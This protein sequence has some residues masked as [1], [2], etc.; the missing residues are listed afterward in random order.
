MKAINA[1]LT[2]DGNAREA[3]KFYAKTLLAEYKEPTFPSMPTIGKDRVIH[4]AVAKGDMLLLASDSQEGVHPTQGNNFSVCVQCD[5][6]A[7]VERLFREFSVGGTVTMPLDNM[8][9]GA[10]FGMLVDK[11]GIG[12]MFN[13]DLPKKTS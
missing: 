11:F 13:C 5:D 6:I 3:M 2:F 7:E 4:A 9:W 8:F 12:W 10:R 1:Y